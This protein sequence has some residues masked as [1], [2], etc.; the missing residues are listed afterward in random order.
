MGVRPSY[1]FFEVEE[2]DPLI[3]ER[4]SV[5]FFF[6]VVV[7][8]GGYRNPLLLILFLFLLFGPFHVPRALAKS[9]A[10]LT[11]VSAIFFRLLHALVHG[12]GAR[13]VVSPAEIVRK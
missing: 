13:W 3:L 7:G 11:F 1:F 4:E 8:K 10:E 12:C 2:D 9:F 5:S 6:V